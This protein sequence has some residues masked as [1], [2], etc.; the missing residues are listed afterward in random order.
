MELLAEELKI[1]GNVNL[2]S[3]ESLQNFITLCQNFIIDNLEDEKDDD[4][5]FTNIN[6]KYYDLH[7]ISKLKTDSS[8][9]RILHTNLAFIY[10]YHE[11]S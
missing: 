2:Q 3:D 5:I 6:S 8:L 9:L 11:K 7:E 10:K 4:N 1:S